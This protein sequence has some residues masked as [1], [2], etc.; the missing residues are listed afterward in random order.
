MTAPLAEQFTPDL[1]RLVTAQISDPVGGELI[2][3]RTGL[4]AET[5]HA[6][7]VP[8]PAVRGLRVDVAEVADA[9]DRGGQR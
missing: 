6:R 5:R 9:F 3:V 8:G 1:V 4:A 7:A 2:A